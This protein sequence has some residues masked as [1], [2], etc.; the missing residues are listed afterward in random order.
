MQINYQEVN[1]QHVQFVLRTKDIGRIRLTSSTTQT[2]VLKSIMV[3]FEVA[4]FPTFITP[5][6][7]GVV[8]IRRNG[9]RLRLVEFLADA[10][11][12]KLEYVYLGGASSRA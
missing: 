10:A 4:Y 12:S 7:L 5:S 11:K 8:H 9:L 2:C 6:Q 3:F 1:A